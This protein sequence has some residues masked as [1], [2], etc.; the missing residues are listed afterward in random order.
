MKLLPTRIPGVKLIEPDVHSDARGTF[1]EA[2]N[3]RDFAELGINATFVQDNHTHSVRH[4][5]R[6]LHYQIRQPQGKLI[7]VSH[8]A[9]FDVAVDLRRDSPFFGQWVGEVL[10][11]E[12]RRMLWIPP[13]FAHGFYVISDVADCQFKCTDY[14]A[15]QHEQR[16]RW[17]DDALDIEWPLREGTWPLLSEKDK[18]NQ[19]FRECLIY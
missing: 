7:I 6:G 4:T 8:G 18:N 17:N 2:W 14:Y 12:N 16:I 11:E 9:I 15:P 3:A 19:R 10:S 13:G 1:M 5:L